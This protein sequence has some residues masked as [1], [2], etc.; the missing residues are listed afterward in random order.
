MI[1][2]TIEADVLHS[3]KR[4]P[5]VGLL[6]SRQTGKTTLAKVVTARLGEKAV[7]LDLERPSDLAKLADPESYLE[8]HQNRLVILDEIQRKPELFP[9]LRSLVDEVPRKGRFLILGSAS[10]ALLRQSSESL[11]GRII[12]HELGPLALNET[13]SQGERGK[14][15]WMRGGYPASF[16]ARSDADSF[17]WRE[18]FIQTY[19][20][21]DLPQLGLRIPAMQLHRFWQM[22]AHCQ[23]QLWNASS[24][25]ASL[26]VSAPT[27]A[28]YLHI[29][30]ETFIIRRIAP[31]QAN[32]KKRLVKSPK[33]YFRDSG[34]LHA[35][36]KLADLEALQGHPVVGSSWEGW[37]IEQIIAQK[38]PGWDY[39]FYRTA[40]GVEV[41]LVLLRPN[42][43]P[44]VVEVKFGRSPSLSRGFHMAFA[45]LQCK[46]GYV[47]YG[48]TEIFPLAKQ[49]TAL[50]VT[51]AVKIYE[52]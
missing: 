4:F 19:L 7:Y 51:E 1:S 13:G 9:L 2:R 42:K 40:S 33:I 8:G 52:T 14:R 37:V 49:V 27:V 20:E 36:L 12:Y 35:L 16:L 25:A 41:D 38:P 3:L 10:S 50:P 44:V 23:G 6:G 32:L 18:A 11:A 39:T 47:V 28:H 29:L 45:D 31:Y 5:I 43:P 48:G 15:L 30:E 26:G 22:L 34:L 21:R 46:N 17:A 24:I